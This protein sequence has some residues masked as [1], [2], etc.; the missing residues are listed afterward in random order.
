MTKN[1]RDAKQ[2]IDDKVNEIW[3]TEPDNIKLVK[4]G[5]V[6]GGAGTG[7]QYFT[8]LVLM[9]TYTLM[10][11]QRLLYP[12]ML[13]AKKP[14]LDLN[15]I[16]IIT[17][18]AIDESFHPTLFLSDLGLSDMH[19]VGKCYLDALDSLESKEDYIE[20]TGSF[21]TFCPRLHR[22]VHY[23]FPWNIGIGAFPQRDSEEMKEIISIAEK[24]E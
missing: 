15:I 9:E 21:F 23:I 19:I 10:L 4:W 2:F 18:A 22:W 24:G 1:W 12:F 16:R 3:M 6:R 8:C 20:L 17:R 14:E 5:I 7:N 11:G 13:M